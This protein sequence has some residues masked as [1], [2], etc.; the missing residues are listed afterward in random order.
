MEIFQQDQNYIKEHANYKTGVCNKSQFN[1]FN[2]SNRIINL[3][4]KINLKNNKY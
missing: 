1:F 3:Y 2:W 4:N